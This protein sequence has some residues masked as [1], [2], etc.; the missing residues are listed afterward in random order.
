MLRAKMYGNK[1]IQIPVNATIDLF[2]REGIL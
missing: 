1:F 2:K